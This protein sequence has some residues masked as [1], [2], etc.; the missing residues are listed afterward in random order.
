MKIG[1]DSVIVCHYLGKLGA[2]GGACGYDEED[3]DDITLDQGLGM[4]A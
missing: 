1:R 2:D 4:E 3:D